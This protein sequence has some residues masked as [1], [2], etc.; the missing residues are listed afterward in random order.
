MELFL[1]TGFAGTSVDAIAKATR[2]SKATIYRYFP[3]KEALFAAMVERAIAN[4]RKLPEIDATRFHDVR[5]LLIEF[6]DRCIDRAVS[7]RQLRLCRVYIFEI[8][9]FELIEK[10]FSRF[11]DRDQNA[12]VASFAVL[13]D[14]RLQ[15]VRAMDRCLQTFF[16]LTVDPVLQAALFRPRS[17]ISARERLAHLQRSVDEFLKIYPPA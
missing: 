10:L 15:G 6:A 9:R 3:D 4:T 5:D 16:N 12:Q 8:Q 13:I 11:D 2:T 1:E 7:P 17:P 14:G